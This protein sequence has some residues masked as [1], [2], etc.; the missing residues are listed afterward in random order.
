MAS[1]LVEIEKAQKNA[2]EVQEK[3]ESQRS[4]QIITAKK[5]IEESVD[6]EE[7]M[8]LADFSDYAQELQKNLEKEIA[9]S[10]KD[11]AARL[12]D[13]LSRATQLLSKAEDFLVG[14]L[15]SAAF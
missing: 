12:D 2:Q 3:A 13:D 15:K 1:A 5:N 14:E 7:Q 11:I 6:K 4:E 10:E 8:L 9:L